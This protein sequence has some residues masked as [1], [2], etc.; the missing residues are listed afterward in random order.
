MSTAV[1]SQLTDGKEH[2]VEDVS[3][4]SKDLMDALT[5]QAADVARAPGLL[6]TNEDVRRIR[7][8]V[9][10]G[11]SLPTKLEEVTHL[12]GGVDNGIPGLEPEA[13][14]DLYVGIQAHARSWSALETTMQKVGSD[15]HVFS[16]NLISIATNVVEFIKSLDSY[17]TLKVGDLT[18]GQIEQLPPVAIMD[19]DSKKLPGLLALVD[20]LKV[21]IKEHSAS[22]TSTRVGVTEFKRRLKDD[23]APDVALKIRL[24][25][26]KDGDEEVTRLTA[27][28]DQ[29]NER[30]N[31]KLAEYEEY[32]D[33][34][35]IGFW[36]GP[37]GGA[38][39]YSIYG[40]KASSALSEKDSLIEKK[41]QIEQKIKQFN[42]LLSDLLAF[43]TSLQDLKAR[44][45]GAASGVSNIESLWVLLEELV[46]S[47]YDRI[48]NTNNA[49]YLVSFVSRFQT[50]MDNWKSI[51]SQ[52]FDLLTAFNEALNEPVA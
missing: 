10:T 18:P 25:S 46:D 37:L 32:S 3:R 16:G 42:K 50:L 41:S 14:C 13:I 35:W 29:L 11:L 49:V 47:S 52:A 27:E 34:K 38:I 30:I 21:Y 48:K 22:T 39:S 44:V 26:S 33:Y 45:D 8:Y 23:I 6:I 12:V 31:Q 5:S 43:E 15:L 9:N 24:A 7:R 17:Q 51:Q 1:E 28:V 19:Q 20:D 4:V 2:T 40:P 36:W